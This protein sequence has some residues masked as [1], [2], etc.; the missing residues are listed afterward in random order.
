MEKN[1]KKNIYVCVCIKLN[2]FAINLKLI[3]Y[4]NIINQPYFNK[5]LF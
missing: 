4:Y 3:Q 2:D 1:L 5:K